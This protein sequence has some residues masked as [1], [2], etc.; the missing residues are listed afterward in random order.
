MNARVH[1]ESLVVGEE[2]D[3]FLSSR[4]MDLQKVGIDA[5]VGLESGVLSVSRLPVRA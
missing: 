2:A 1:G 5:S 4:E 3:F